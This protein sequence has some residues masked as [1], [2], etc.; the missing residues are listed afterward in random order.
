MRDIQYMAWRY[1]AYNR[2]KTTILVLSVT[3]IIFLPA[4]L[5]I[6]VGQSAKA[7]TI[8]AEATPLIIGAKGSPLELVLNT[9]YFESD[10]PPSIT[11]SES[12]RVSD[13]QLAVAIP[14][15]TRFKTRGFSI[16]GTTLDYFDF[17][18]LKIQTGRNMAM[19]GECVLGS[20]VAAQLGLVPGSAL[21][22][23]PESVFDLAGVY[24]LKMN[25]VGILKPTGTPDD[26]IVL[27]DLKTAWIIQGLAHGHQDMS[28]PEA[29]AGVLKRDGDTIVANASVMKYNEITPA[30]MD[31]F[32]FHG[33]LSDFPITTIIAV[34]PNLKSSTLLQ[35]KYLGDDERVQITKPTAVM[36]ELLETILTIQRYVVAAVVVIGFSTLMTAVLVFMLSLRLRKRE[37]ETMHRIGG[38]KRRVMG[39][40]GTEI[41][42]VLLLGLAFAGILTLIASRFGAELIRILVL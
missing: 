21:V 8:R 18:S 7:L 24:P 40:I 33:D 16:V 2:I 20:S 10:A 29:A 12:Q 14:L 25:V 9:L 19:M 22:S 23:S 13:S 31:S 26:R 15:Y 38:S 4:G 1:L 37:I 32:H 27:V 34:P 5:K 3:L 6:L 17:R 35:G 36:D 28:K 30:N 11:F 42:V 39:L 41:A